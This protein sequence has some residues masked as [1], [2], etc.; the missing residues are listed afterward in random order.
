METK[1]VEMTYDSEVNAAYV[2]LQKGVEIQNPQVILESPNLR[3]QIIIDLAIDGSIVGIEILY[4][5]P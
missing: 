2:Y 1:L 5:K 4:Y 3:Q